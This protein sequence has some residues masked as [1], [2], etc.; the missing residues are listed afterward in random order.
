MNKP[1][2]FFQK[3]IEQKLFLNDLLFYISRMNLLQCERRSCEFI[4][5]K[6]GFL[7]VCL[8]VHPSV[9]PSIICMFIWLIEDVILK[10]Y[11]KTKEGL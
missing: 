10:R 4:E 11:G 1:I 7:C 8:S 6:C 9:Y 3:K 2:C 5:M